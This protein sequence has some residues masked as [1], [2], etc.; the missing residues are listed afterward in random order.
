IDLQT[1][2][3]YSD[4]EQA[5]LKIHS[6][7]QN[8]EQPKA[9]K[10]ARSNLTESIVMC[11]EIEEENAAK[12][13][14]PNVSDKLIT[15]HNHP[16]DMDDEK[17]NSKNTF[18]AHLQAPIDVSQIKL[19]KSHESQNSGINSR[20]FRKFQNFA[21]NEKIPSP[22]F[23]MNQLTGRCCSEFTPHHCVKKAEYCHPTCSH[24]ISHL[25]ALPSTT[26]RQHNC[27]RCPSF[28]DNMKNSSCCDNV[29]KMN[30]YKSTT[31]S[32]IHTNELAKTKGNETFQTFQNVKI[33]R[34]TANCSKPMHRQIPPNSNFV[35]PNV[36]I[37]VFV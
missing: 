35:K 11:N 34:K 10:P 36:S 31:D 22:T 37:F 6:N 26:R 18:N 30:N 19:E 9:S 2:N 8:C 17:N 29:C 23:D 20:G 4:E 1:G 27:Q 32:A 24:Q 13:N 14:R 28:H 33:C 21:K 5:Q 12:N 16:E 15:D 7:G 25:S 3:E